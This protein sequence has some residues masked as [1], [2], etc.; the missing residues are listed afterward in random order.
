MHQRLLVIDVSEDK[1]DPLVFINPGDPRRATA[2]QVYAGRLPVGAR[3][4]RR[5]R[6]RRTRPRARARP[7]RPAVR[8]RGRWPARGLHPAR[9]GPP[10]RQAVRRLPLAL[11]RE[12]VR[13]KLAKQ[14]R[15]ARRPR[16]RAR[17]ARR[18]SDRPPCRTARCDRLRRHA[19]VRGARAAT[20]SPRTRHRIAGGLHAARPTG[21]PRP[22]SWPPSPV[23][24][25]R[26]RAR[27]SDV[28]SR[29]RSRT[30]TRAAALRALRR[31]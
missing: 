28:A 15:R 4:L 23:K 12:L 18:R 19:G 5:R 22:R 31:T 27:H 6:A 26:A 1:N 10:R 29:N 16:S 7:R 8:A 30:P 13:K 20:R 14:R 9:D 24:A 3:H 25:A 2:S 11:K 21:G 17:R